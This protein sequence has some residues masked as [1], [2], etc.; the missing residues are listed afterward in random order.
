MGTPCLALRLLAKL[1]AL[2]APY[3]VGRGVYT[4]DTVIGLKGRIVYEAPGLI[5]L[6]AA[7]RALEDAVLTKQQ[8]RFKPDVARKW[9]E[10]VYEGF[11]NDPLKTD[12]EAFL[13]SSQA[14]VNGEVVLETS[15]RTRGCRGRAFAAPAERQGRDVCAVGGLG[16]G[17]GGRLSSSCSA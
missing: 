1:N 16:C 12:L 13:K 17:R 15:W 6:L 11:F 14:K 4:G 5:A 7:H 2:F 10:L 9:V 8:N 3:G